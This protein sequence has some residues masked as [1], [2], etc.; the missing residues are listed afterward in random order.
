MGQER[1]TRRQKNIS[2]VLREKK[3]RTGS[4]ASVPAK[5]KRSK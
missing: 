1:V 4:K 3:N 2:R 5:K